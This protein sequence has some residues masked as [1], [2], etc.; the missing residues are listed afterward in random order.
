MRGWWG[1]CVVV[2]MLVLS[3]LAAC[4]GG[5]AAAPVV[6]A[7]QQ[8]EA[9]AARQTVAPSQL[10]DVHRCLT[11]L[12]QALHA[13]PTQ[14]A[15]GLQCLAG[16]YRGLTPQGDACALQ[17]DGGQGRFNFQHGEHTVS[18]SWDDVAFRPGLP[19]LHN[20]EVASTSARQPGVQ[21]TRYSAAPAA[22]TETLSL[23]AGE[24][25]MGPAGLPEMNYLR[26]E[27]GKT[28]QV[29]CRFGA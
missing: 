23:R 2:S 14:R 27:E 11:R 22:V 24:P 10:P 26:V 16:T 3:L 1:G 17:V 4:G 25:S 9:Q 21:L 13:D 5:D 28:Q 7:S 12:T 29:R 15:V 8:R 18:I 20:L 19:A 6:T